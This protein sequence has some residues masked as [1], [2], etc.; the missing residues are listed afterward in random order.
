MIA[1]GIVLGT[2]MGIIAFGPMWLTRDASAASLRSANS[3][4][5]KIGN[6]VRLCR[7]SDLLIVD[8]LEFTEDDDPPACGV[9]NYNISADLSEG[10]IK[11]CEKG[12][13]RTIPTIASSAVGW[14]DDGTNV[15]LD[16]STDEVVIGSATPV[17]SAKFSIDGDADQIQ[18]AIQANAGQA[19]NLMEIEDSSGTEMFHFSS[20]GQ[21]GIQHT[22]V[23]GNDHSLQVTTDANGLG[24]IKGISSLYTTGAMGAADHTNAIIVNI[25]ESASTGGVVAGFEVLATDSGASTVHGFVSGVGVNPILHQSGAFGAVAFCEEETTGPTFTDCTV[26]FNAAGTD[27]QIWDADND[28]IYIGEAASFESI[29][30]LFDTVTNNP[31]IKPT[32]EYSQVGPVWATFTPTD[33][34]NGARNNGVIDWEK[35]NLTGWVAVAVDGDSAFWIRITRTTNSLTGPIEDLVQTADPVTFSWNKDG[36]ITAK[37]LTLS[38]DLVATNIVP[39]A[40]FTITQNSVVPFTSVETG[41]VVNTLVLK[42]GKVGINDSNPNRP[43][44]VKGDGVIAR[45]TAV[46][47]DGGAFGALLIDRETNTNT[48]GIGISFTAGDSASLTARQEY[49]YIGAEIETNTSGSE[50]G[51]LLFLVTDGGTLRKEAM[52]IVASQRIGVG[53]NDPDRLTHAEVSDAVISAV[54]FANRLSHITS[55]TAAAGFG[56]GQEFELEGA[57]G[58]N[59]V[60]GDISVEWTDASTGAEDADMVFSLAVGGAVAAE[61]GRLT[62]AGQFSILGDLIIGVEDAGTKSLVIKG[63]DATGSDEGGEVQFFLADDHD[64]INE[65]YVIDAFEDDLRFFGLTGAPKM[66]L[67]AEGYFVIDS[68]AKTTTGDPT[69]REGMLYWNTVDNVVKMF[70][71]GGWRILASW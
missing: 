33:G 64:T 24:D 49:G 12:V 70:A 59:L 41:A 13:S 22:G 21:L 69:G 54:T 60:A 36:D 55:G 17:K 43:L 61:K 39:G 46:A 65:S 48:H 26:A 15:R 32:F 53:T 66:T 50:G 44:I 10:A 37:G 42:D 5:C 25:D 45:F 28:R 27:I 14:I 52:R 23:L 20:S 63:S 40:D 57:D 68:G 67:T 18:F 7:P 51:A 11:I 47:T 3:G 6:T 1:R 62:S 71:D 58:T 9:N 8:A 38:G 56:V 2:I 34:T 29:S 4:M 35:V 31:G 30:W 16:T 19:A